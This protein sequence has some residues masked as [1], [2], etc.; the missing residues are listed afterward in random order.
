MAACHS[1]LGRTDQARALVAE[2]LRRKPDFRYSTV[3]LGF[4]D[5][6][7]AEHVIDGFRKAGLPE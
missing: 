4:R 5:P 7:D 6:E 2:V 1:Q 3:D